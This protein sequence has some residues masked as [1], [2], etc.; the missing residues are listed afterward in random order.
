VK[1]KWWGGKAVND[2]LVEDSA[3]KKITLIAGE[4]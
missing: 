4:V 2:Q 3:Y 1:Q